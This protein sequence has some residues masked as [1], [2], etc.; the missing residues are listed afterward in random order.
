MMQKI[1]IKLIV[2]NNTQ[3]NNTRPTKQKPRKTEAFE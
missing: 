1:N 2:S 3:E